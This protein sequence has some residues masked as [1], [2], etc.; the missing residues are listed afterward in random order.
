MKENDEH[1]VEAYI[2]RIET[3]LAGPPQD[4]RKL[5]QSSTMHVIF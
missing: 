3:L 2:Y 4:T 5:N 1:S